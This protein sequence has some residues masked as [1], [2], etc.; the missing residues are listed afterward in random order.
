MFELFLLLSL[1]GTGLYF[2]KDDVKHLNSFDKENIIKANHNNI[3]NRGVERNSRNLHQ[4]HVNSRNNKSNDYKSNVYK[5]NVKKPLHNIN[6][7][8]HFQNNNSNNNNQNNRN[9]ETMISGDMKYNNDNGVYS[10]LLGKQ[11]LKEEFKHNNMVPFF[12]KAGISIDQSDKL[13][14]RKL[15]QNTGQDSFKKKK[16]EQTPLWKPT[17]GYTNI[18]GQQ[19]DEKYTLNKDRY[20]IGKSR[21]NELPFEKEYIQPFEGYN[22]EYLRD[23]Q[24]LDAAAK[25]NASVKHQRGESNV[26]YEGR[27]GPPTAMNKKRGNIGETMKHRPDKFHTLE[28]HPV[29]PTTGAVIREG[30]RPEC[31]I[32]PK[33]K[34]GKFSN[35]FGTA[36]ASYEKEQERPLI[37]KS[38]KITYKED[39]TRNMTAE[40]MWSGQKDPF[41]YGKNSFNLPANERDTTQNNTQLLN[42]DSV[43]K[44]IIAPFSDI[45]KTT[46]KET[47]IHNEREGNMNTGH[48]KLTAHDPNDVAKT[49]I[50]ETNIHNER[51]GNF[52]GPVKLTVYDPNDVMKTTIKETNIHNERD[53]N[54]TTN[55]PKGPAYD[56]NNVLKTT[57]KETNIHNDRE[58]NVGSLQQ[59]NKGYLTNPQYA[60][61]TNKESTSDIDYYGTAGS[62]D[63]K[64]TSYAADYN[65]RPNTMKEPLEVGRDPT[66]EGVKVSNGGDTINL[67]INK[68]DSDYVNIREVAQTKIYPSIPYEV[69]CQITSD[70]SSL[71]NNKLANRIGGDLLN[72]FNK[73]PYTQPLNSFA[74]N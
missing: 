62:M 19:L 33:T 2:N 27:E 41:D 10:Q 4:Q 67:D 1:I 40:D 29:M 52:T 32:V 57:I 34:R 35:L 28:E 64:P 17:S 26:S 50:K 45:A 46:I 47:N 61:P 37:R 51:E 60:P 8:E 22:N 18:Y 12:K 69:P 56:P 59:T 7:K 72:A 68:L 44:A 3:Y 39:T 63:D 31:T 16:K 66:P 36:K 30:K 42:V 5:R 70:K 53:G 55:Y 73:N 49:T 21:K 24:E 74:Y 54:L 71:D 15:E 14:Q 25:L 6:N 58:G 65:M 11:V 23:I 48:H 38:S 9:R 43:V 13:F 20:S